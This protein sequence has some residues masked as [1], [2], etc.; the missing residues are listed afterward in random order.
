[1]FSIPC[2]QYTCNLI[3]TVTVIINVKSYPLLMFGLKYDD[4]G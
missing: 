4:I 1:M 2:T 3:Y